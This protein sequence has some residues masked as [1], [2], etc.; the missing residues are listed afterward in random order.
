MSKW[1]DYMISAVRFN[2]AH[3]HIDRVRTHADSGET[4]GASVEQRRPDIVDAIKKR[5]TF[6]TIFSNGNGKWNKGQPVYVV[7]INGTE[8]IKTHRPRK[9]S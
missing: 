8:Y 1:A 3:T 9:G 7:K 6:M 4:I 5:N 2:S